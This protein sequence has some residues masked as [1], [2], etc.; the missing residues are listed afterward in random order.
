SRL[1]V[2]TI[3]MLI[4]ALLTVVR[5]PGDSSGR[6]IMAGAMSAITV[7]VLR[8]TSTAINDHARDAE[9]L[10]HAAAHDG[11]TGMPNRASLLRH[12]GQA[13]A[14]VEGS[15]GVAVICLGLDGFKLVN[16]SW[17]RRAGDEL[18]LSV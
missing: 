8:R 18:L 2:V 13:L 10:A 14:R 17:G 9:V 5:P 12:T 11:L 6:L 7:A 3:S 4:P 15:V 1:A 16:D